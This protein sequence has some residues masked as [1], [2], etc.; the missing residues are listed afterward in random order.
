MTDSN[1]KQSTSYRLSQ[2]VSQ[3]NM[4]QNMSQEMLHAADLNL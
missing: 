3:T 2:G 4:T 1:P